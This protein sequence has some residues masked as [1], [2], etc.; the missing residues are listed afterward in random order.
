MTKQEFYNTYFDDAVE[1]SKVCGIDPLLLLTQA[2]HESAYGQYAYGNNFH[3]IKKGKDWKGDVQLLKTWEESDR[4]DLKFPEIIS[5]TEVFKDGKIYYKYRIR[6]YFRKYPTPSDGFIDHAKFLL[7][8]RYKKVVEN[9]NNPLQYFK[10]LKLAGYATDSDY[11]ERM[12]KIY[13]ELLK[14]HNEANKQ[15]EG[16]N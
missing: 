16:S 4:N 10:E 8:K 12:F 2:A 11:P 13:S 6:D 1:A 7:K 9:K 5:I 14:I 3:G 15:N